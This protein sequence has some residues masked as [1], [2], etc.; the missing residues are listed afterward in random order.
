MRVP[1]EA[2]GGPIIQI[3]FA[4]SRV[5]GGAGAPGSTTRPC[6]PGRVMTKPRPTALTPCRELASS[7]SQP[8]SRGSCLL[9][10][11]LL[12]ARSAARCL[13]MASHRRGHAS[14]GLL[15]LDVEVLSCRPRIATL[16]LLLRCPVVADIATRP[17]LACSRQLVI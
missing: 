13:L 1:G 16:K 14:D 9:P 2:R 3:S 5:A 4:Q 17:A 15:G 10:L 7:S 6:R 12:G 11:P 8:C